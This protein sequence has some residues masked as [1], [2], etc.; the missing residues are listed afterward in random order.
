MKQKQVKVSERAYYMLKSKA[1]S[2]EYR[3]H[4]VTGVIDMM[5]FDEFTTQGSGR[6]TGTTGIKQK[7]RKKY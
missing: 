6:P 3:G 2:P 7:P 1:K 5:L 4:G